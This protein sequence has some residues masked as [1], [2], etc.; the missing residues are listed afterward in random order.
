MAAIHPAM[1]EGP[2]ADEISI[3]SLPI[4]PGQTMQLWYDFG[5]DWRFNDQA[6]TDRTNQARCQGREA[7]YP[8]EPRQS[9]RTISRTGMNNRAYLGRRRREPRFEMPLPPPILRGSAGAAL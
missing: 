5:D 9:A 1:D 6:G 4:D 2:W 3:G 8:R 7:P